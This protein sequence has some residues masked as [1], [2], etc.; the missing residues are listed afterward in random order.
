[1]YKQA[2]TRQF[3]SQARTLGSWSVFGPTHK[4]EVGEFS[5]THPDS[6]WT[7]T[8]VITED[9]YYWV[10][11]FSARHPV[12]GWVKGDYETEVRAKSRKALEHFMEWH[13]A[14]EWDYYDI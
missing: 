11:D 7:I 14:E 6:G 12:F 5:Y 2:F 13:P 10:N 9:Y 4:G 8:G 3:D 1:M